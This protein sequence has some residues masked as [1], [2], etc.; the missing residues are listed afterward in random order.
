MVF[1]SCILLFYWW[2][3]QIWCYDGFKRAG[4]FFQ[5]KTTCDEVIY[6]LSQIQ[7]EY[8]FH[9]PLCSP[10]L[11]K[12]QPVNSPPASSYQDLAPLNCEQLLLCS[13]H[14]SSEQGRKEESE[15]GTN[16]RNQQQSSTRWNKIYRYFNYSHIN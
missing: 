7:T 9:Y 10:G 5:K 4:G 11:T 12:T 1:L 3:C 2:W 15:E 6:G 14:C 8:S 13:P 16:R